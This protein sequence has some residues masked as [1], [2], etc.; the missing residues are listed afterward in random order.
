MNQTG[1]IEDFAKA[2]I[3][4][5]NSAP[6]AMLNMHT[7]T[8]YNEELK[9]KIYTSCNID[10]DK[11]TSFSNCE[12]DNFVSKGVKALRT[13]VNIDTFKQNINKYDMLQS[14]LYRSDF[15]KLNDTNE[16]LTPNIV[17]GDD[18]TMF[19]FHNLFT[20]L[21]EKNDELA[22]Q[23]QSMEEMRHNIRIVTAAKIC[24]EL[25]RDETFVNDNKN[26]ILSCFIIIFGVLTT[27]LYN[28]ERNDRLMIKCISNDLSA[29][30]ETVKQHML[31]DQMERI[32]L[33]PKLCVINFVAQLIE[34]AFGTFTEL[35]VQNIPLADDINSIDPNVYSEDAFD[36]LYDF[37][38]T[39]NNELKDIITNA[40]LDQ[41]KEYHGQ[42]IAMVNNPLIFYTNSSSSLPLF[43]IKYM[44][45]NTLNM[46][47]DYLKSSTFALVNTVDEINN[48]CTNCPSG[49]LAICKAIISY[50]KV[51][52]ASLSLETD[53]NA[54]CAKDA[55]E[56]H[57]MINDLISVNFNSSAET[58]NILMNGL[59][60]A[61][62][63]LTNHRPTDVEKYAG[64]LPN[65]DHYKILISP[66][67]DPLIKILGGKLNDKQELIL[68]TAAGY[69]KSWET[70]AR[71]FDLSQNFDNCYNITENDDG[72]E[73]IKYTYKYLYNPNLLANFVTKMPTY[74]YEQEI[75]RFISRKLNGFIYNYGIADKDPILKS[76]DKCYPVKGPYNV[77]YHENNNIQHSI[78]PN[79]TTNTNGL[80]PL[81]LDPPVNLQL[82]EIPAVD[83]EISKTL[84]KPK[85]H[86]ISLPDSMF[87][88]TRMN[89]ILLQN[90]YSPQKDIYNATIT[91]I[92][93]A[94]VPCILNENYHQ[95]VNDNEGNEYKVYDF[96]GMYDTFHNADKDHI[97]NHHDYNFNLLLGDPKSN[98]LKFVNNNA[99]FNFIDSLLNESIG[100][101]M[102][103]KAFQF[104]N[105]GFDTGSQKL[106]GGFATSD[107]FIERFINVNSPITGNT[108]NEI[109][110]NAYVIDDTLKLTD[111]NLPGKSLYSYLFKSGASVSDLSKN[112]VMFS[113][114]LNYFHKY[115]LSFNSMFNQ[116]CF[117]SILFNSACLRSSMSKIHSIAEQLS[118]AFKSTT[119]ESYKQGLLSFIADYLQYYTQD[120]LTIDACKDYRYQINFN[121][122][123]RDA[124]MNM[125]D[126]ID[127]MKS[128]EKEDV[129]VKSPNIA[130]G[131]Q[132]VMPSISNAYIIELL[133][134]VS[135]NTDNKNAK[136][137]H[138]VQRLFGS[139]IME[140]LR[141]LDSSSTYIS[142]LFML[143]KQTSYYDNQLD[144][145]VT[146]IHS[147]SPE[148]FSVN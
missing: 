79:T 40:N 42:L 101:F 121:T 81:D 138:K 33:L 48:E 77:R 106:E 30:L 64:E 16:F 108:D 58:I 56:L 19:G 69:A 28:I 31:F 125:K 22:V 82:K 94:V 148:P 18:D 47:N 102:D 68:A 95:T 99:I 26:Y 52:F 66:N 1:T 35:S 76:S 21:F 72:Y 136:D 70:R 147:D 46:A 98:N 134:Y 96:N 127:N 80:T 45:Y 55:Y 27:Q 84:I 89:N 38:K 146:F 36:K 122:S 3:G 116:L 87:Q 14:A 51:I 43:V 49:F 129:C 4:I 6:A 100:N 78:I 74:N 118:K 11:E 126:I 105:Y 32:T 92:N 8:I 34:W 9:N 140:A 91:D 97:Y 123:L 110:Y 13:E 83:V 85:P 111:T 7:M 37:S 131:N 20:Y 115:N 5:N 86:T 10:G 141:H 144:K 67:S 39:V 137:C 23:N 109:L 107:T 112:D 54:L 44:S 120:N 62:N 103:A 17:H 2:E 63:T 133:K 124:N 113:L 57:Q 29:D 41:I 145:D 25:A 59:A 90:L 15:V 139:G 60:T 128:W 75:I 117:P 12:R 88:H 65:K 130:L 93:Q 73:R 24:A 135:I 119:K 71:Y 143:L 104:N 142:V 53:T 50:I 132:Y 61:F 114:I